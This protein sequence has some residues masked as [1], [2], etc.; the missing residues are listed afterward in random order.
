MSESSPTINNN[1]NNNNNNNTELNN[2]NNGK[3][4][5]HSNNNSNALNYGDFKISISIPPDNPPIARVDQN[6][7]EYHSMNRCW[8]VVIHNSNHNKGINI[9]D[10]QQQQQQ[11]L[12]ANPMIEFTDNMNL[13][14][15]ELEQMIFLIDMIKNERHISLS[16]ID[17][18]QASEQRELN[19]AVQQISLKQKALSDMGNRLISGAAR[20]KASV[21]T[22]SSW[23]SDVSTLRSKWR[24]KGKDSMTMMIPTNKASTKKLSIDYGFYTSGSIVDQ[25][26]ADLSRGNKGEMNIEFPNLP[27]PSALN[28]RLY[29]S[30]KSRDSKTF[31]NNSSGQIHRLPVTDHSKSYREFEQLLNRVD[32]L[33]LEDARKLSFLKCSNLLNKAHKY[34]FHSELFD[35]LNREASIGNTGEIVM[36]TEKEIRIECGGLNLFIGMVDPKRDEDSE[37]IGGSATADVDER[38]DRERDLL[39]L[40]RCEKDSS[41]SNNNNNID[42]EMTM[43]QQQQHRLFYFVEQMSN[44]PT[45]GSLID[46][47]EFESELTSSSSSNNNVYQQPQQQNTKKQK[48]SST[49]LINFND[50]TINSSIGTT[51][52]TTTTNNKNHKHMNGSINNRSLATRSSSSSSS[53]KKRNTQQYFHPQLIELIKYFQIINR[54]IN[55]L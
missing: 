9:I 27:Y 43:E 2:N 10:Q 55:I 24:L 15:I 51:T 40:S 35:S 48:H 46:L 33:P 19:D 8:R 30:V 31:S 25:T 42:G 14:R 20:M 7:T 41:S 39:V 21:A 26:E 23:W 53:S 50:L 28:K 44:K 4:N 32:T 29:I 34:Q 37:S 11:L 18:P 45:I 12:Q 5:G 47:E 38:E 16:S 49:S 54:E 1:N 17:K 13:A 6:G 36:L 3:V 22:A 52:A